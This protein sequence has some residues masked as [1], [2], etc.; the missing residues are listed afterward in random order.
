MKSWYAIDFI[1]EKVGGNWKKE[2][3]GR[4]FFYGFFL[5]ASGFI[6]SYVNYPVK[7]M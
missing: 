1:E 5:E 6:S 3:K 2:R 7:S 4:S